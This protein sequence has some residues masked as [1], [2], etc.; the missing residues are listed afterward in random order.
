MET[1][2]LVLCALWTG[3][4]LPRGSYFRRVFPLMHYPSPEGRGYRFGLC[5]AERLE[6]P[7]K[8]RQFPA[9]GCK[10]APGVRLDL[11]AGGLSHPRQCL[12]SALLGMRTEPPG[13]SLQWGRIPRDSKRLLWSVTTRGKC[14][15]VC[16]CYLLEHQGSDWTSVPEDY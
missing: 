3:E 7:G 16:L 1:N 14:S 9:Q 5:A 6:A 10:T 13:K 4:M 12:R 8:A 2:I 11:L 15:K